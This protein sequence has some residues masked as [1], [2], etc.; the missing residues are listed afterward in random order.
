V[1][2]W[3]TDQVLGEQDYCTTTIDIQDNFDVCEGGQ[4]L[5]GVISGHISTESSQDVREVGVTLSGSGLT[6]EMTDGTGAYAFPTMPLGGTYSVMP[7]KNTDWK[8]GVSTLDL[9]LIQKHLLGLQA[10]SSPYKMIAADANKSNSISALDIVALRR[11]ILGMVTEIPENTSWRFVDKAYDFT[12]P[13][14]PFDEQFAESFEVAPFST[15]LPN[16]DFIAIKVGDINKTVVANLNNI[17]TRTN[18]GTITL[19]VEDRLVKAG[20]TV[21]VAIEAGHQMSL[22]GYQFTLNFD[23]ARLAFESY[24]SGAM[25]VNDNNFNLNM[26]REGMVPTSWSDVQAHGLSAGEVLFTVRFQALGSGKLSEILSINSDPTVA[27]AYNTEG[28]VLNLGIQFTNPGVVQTTEFELLENRPNP[29]TDAT[30]VVFITPQAS[31]A[32]LTI[33][34]VTGRIVME[35]VVNAVPGRNEVEVKGLTT[36]GVLYCQ[37][38]TDG[39][40]ATRKMIRME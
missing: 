40:S 7:E 13:A 2:I 31:E 34:D 17:V 18:P 35:Q 39:F 1:Q 26:T 24:V 8:N 30:T 9:I 29:F 20:E 4:T 28:E 33:Y 16:V 32:T 6:A 10:L 12:D 27:E 36:K 37:V 11:L 5:T 3:V 15:T 19:Q 25:F 23:A 14:Y 38:S 21:E 22:E